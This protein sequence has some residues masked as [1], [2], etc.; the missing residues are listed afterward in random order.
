LTELLAKFQKPSDMV[1][2]SCAYLISTMLF[3]K[4]LWF[5]RFEVA[6]NW[7]CSTV[8]KV[9]YEEHE[10]VCILISTKKLACMFSHWKLM[11]T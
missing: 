3:I 8:V 2:N 4:T 6:L 1:G 10:D 9:N 11:C 5:S 7:N